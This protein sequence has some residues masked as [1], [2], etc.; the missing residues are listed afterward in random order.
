MTTLDLSPTPSSIDPGSLASRVKWSIVVP[1]IVSALV[2]GTNGYHRFLSVESSRDVDSQTIQ[3]LVR[4]VEAL[5]QQSAVQT[6][7][8]QRMEAQQNADV[9]YRTERR[10][11]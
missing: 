3:T 7:I 1:W 10:R 8:L 6:A 2:V 11:P 5:E 9:L 4:R